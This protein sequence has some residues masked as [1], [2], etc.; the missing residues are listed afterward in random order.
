MLA[1]AA[2]LWVIGAGAYAVAAL[3]PLPGVL[4]LALPLGMLLL[5]VG[6]A[7]YAPT[8]DALP[9]EVAP[10]EQVG[11]YSAV[12]QMGWGVSGAIAP[13][14]AAVLLAA[15]HAPLWA[16]LTVTGAALAAAFATLGRR[17]G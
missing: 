6:E 5:G 4:V 8:A 3:D 12:F 9:L 17:R 7:A 14:L 11:R 1:G 10:P 16:T 13:L 2:V 15:G